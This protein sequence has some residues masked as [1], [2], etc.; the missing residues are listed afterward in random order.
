MFGAVRTVSE[1]K[2]SV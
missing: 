1:A 2:I